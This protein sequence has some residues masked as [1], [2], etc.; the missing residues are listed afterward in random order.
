M[1]SV[2]VILKF[3]AKRSRGLIFERD[4][5]WLFYFVVNDGVIILD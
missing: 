4:D 5:W 1:I 2:C 3:E